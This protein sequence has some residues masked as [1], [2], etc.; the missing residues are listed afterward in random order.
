MY[1]R[2]DR[3]RRPAIPVTLHALAT[4]LLATRAMLREGQAWLDGASGRV[5]LIISAVS[6]GAQGGERSAREE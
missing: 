4:V 5:M 2:T 3:P 6:V 1:R